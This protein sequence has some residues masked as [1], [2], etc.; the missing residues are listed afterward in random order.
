LPRRDFKQYIVINEIGNKCNI[1]NIITFCWYHPNRHISRSPIK[2]AYL[3]AVNSTT[4]FFRLL[5]GVFAREKVKAGVFNQ[6]TK[7]RNGTQTK[8]IIQ[9]NNN[10]SSVRVIRC[11]VCGRRFSSEPVKVGLGTV[12]CVCVL[13]KAK[14]SS[15]PMCTCNT[16]HPERCWH[17]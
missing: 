1:R 2:N 14:G 3:N 5:F 8:K 6:K 12:L 13:Y 11:I 10:M 16:Y 17:V 4:D 15:C 7:G 9:Y